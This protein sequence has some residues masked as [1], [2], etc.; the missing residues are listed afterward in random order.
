MNV[1][2]S[3]LDPFQ[4]QLSRNVRLF[5]FSPSWHLA[6][7]LL[8]FSSVPFLFSFSCLT[9]LFSSFFSPWYLFLFSFSSCRTS[10]CFS[11]VLHFSRL[12]SFFFNSLLSQLCVQGLK[13][14]G[15]CRVPDGIRMSLLILTE[16]IFVEFSSIPVICTIL[17]HCMRTLWKWICSRAVHS[18][19]AAYSADS[20]QV[21]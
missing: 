11:Y 17:A 8:Y 15:D 6:F 13:G 14:H 19:I 18:F 16:L 12:F 7:F 21:T 3:S 1:N 5:L 10:S 9:S 2:G 4:T 20:M